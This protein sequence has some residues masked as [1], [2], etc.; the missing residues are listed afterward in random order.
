LVKAAIKYS[1]TSVNIGEISQ[2]MI[3]KSY[4]I[5]FTT[6]GLFYREAI[7]AS[8]L[9]FELKDWQLV[10]EI[11]LKDNLLKARTESS[12]IR[13]T[14]E[15]IQRL[16]VLTTLQLQVLVDGSRQEQNQILW[17]AVCKQYQF[18]REF[19][20]EVVRKKYL[21]LDWELTYLDFDIFFNHKAEWSDSLDQITDSTRKKLRQVLFRILTEAEIISSSNMILPI[22]ISPRVATVLLEEE[23][24]NFIIFPISETDIRKYKN[25]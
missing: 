13:T 2:I 15:L 24:L 4:K 14:R 9:F 18:V 19:A 1:I 6:G 5:S 3:N 20:I 25:Q 8:E 16:Q 21:S 7:K 23:P 11:I 22:I 10:R 12:L 17:L